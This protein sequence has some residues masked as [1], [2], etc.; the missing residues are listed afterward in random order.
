MP[1]VPQPIPVTDDDMI[2]V[3]V[4]L[5][6]RIDRLRPLRHRAPEVRPHLKESLTA[7]R[8]FSPRNTQWRLV[9]P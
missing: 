2:A 1:L 4:A 3:R 9:K 6:Q 5:R 7:L 8:R